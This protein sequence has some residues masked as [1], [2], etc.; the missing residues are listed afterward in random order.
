MKNSDLQLVEFLSI[1]DEEVLLTIMEMMDT[2]WSFDVD[3]FKIYQSDR[4]I[5]P[6]ETKNRKE[7]N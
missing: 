3:D 4:D 7:L 2:F 6:K 5:P 1:C